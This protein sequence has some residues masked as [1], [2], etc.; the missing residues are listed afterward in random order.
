MAGSIASLLGPSAE[1]IVYDLQQAEKLRQQA[2]L[3]QS[4]A[5]QETQAGRDFYQSGYNLT[6]GLGKALAGMFGYSEQMTDPRIAKSVAMRKVFSDLSAE[7][8]N[9]PSK[10]SMLSEMAD[11]YDLPELK[12]W[13]ADRERKLLEEESV[14]SAR[15]AK[16]AADAAETYSGA[17]TFISPDGRRFN[18]IRNSRGVIFEV[19]Q[20][21][22]LLAAPQNTVKAPL[23]E[24]AAGTPS[25]VLVEQALGYVEQHPQFK[26]LDPESKK[27]ISIDLAGKIK[28]KTSKGM[29]APE[30]VR[31]GLIELA[32]SG[33][34][35]EKELSIFSEFINSAA[36]L[37][38]IDELVSPD[39][40]YDALDLT[41]NKQQEQ[42]TTQQQTEPV[43]QK[44]VLAEGETVAM[45]P[46][47]NKK[48]VIG[49]D[50]KVKSEFIE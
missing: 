30:A 18:G 24:R 8:L 20:D 44:T 15:E 11:Q 26:E 2:Q 1:E 10:I 25:N 6:M 46:T 42:L 47:T 48:Y 36:S 35:K 5:G 23:E 41:E 33:K 50:G 39:M 49:V 43:K 28:E 12:L 3:Q 16:A 37:I 29:P 7:D 31:E 45:D 22:S 27:L 9:D 13:T 17:G 32:A 19:L 4:L 34:V 40:F 21:G 14:R 38:G